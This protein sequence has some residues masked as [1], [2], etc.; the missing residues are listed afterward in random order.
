MFNFEY[1]TDFKL[2]EMSKN[3][4]AHIINAKTFHSSDVGIRQIYAEVISEGL[5]KAVEQHMN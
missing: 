3:T 4:E 1:K 5:D 2:F